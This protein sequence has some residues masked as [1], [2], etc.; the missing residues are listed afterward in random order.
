[1]ITTTISHIRDML[2]EESILYLLRESG[3]RP[4]G[5]EAESDPTL[6][7][8]PEGLGVVGRGEVHHLGTVADFIPPRPFAPPQ[9][10]LLEARLYA[11]STPLDL[12]L[13]R[14]AA[15]IL[16]DVNENWLVSGSDLPKQRYQYAY[17]LLSA[18]GFSPAAQCFAFVQEIQLLH[19][20]GIPPL[21][22][23]LQAIQRINHNLFNAPTWNAIT[24][25]L[26]ELRRFMQGLLWRGEDERLLRLLV[27]RVAV[28][29]LLRVAAAARAVVGLRLGLLAGRLPLPLLL[30]DAAALD[31]LDELE[32][33]IVPNRS[34]WLL[35]PTTADTP[36]LACNFP[37]ELLALYHRQG[38]LGSP[39][40]IHLFQTGPAPTRL[41][42]L[43][44]AAAW[45]A[46][47]L[48]G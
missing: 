25:H 20:G 23:L 10:L 19:L 4:T 16:K 21:V 31:S 29:P 17:A 2:L 11:D 38:L 36:A 18:T 5:D 28:K 33:T 1:M 47:V 15:G 45:A 48:A 26:P 40:E 46:A 44:L 22:P 42:T 37:G 32:W 12:P 3:Y 9:R 39:A 34:G 6:R 7:R 14:Q 30:P 35:R 8:S 24:L 13:V 27:P 41:L 43:P